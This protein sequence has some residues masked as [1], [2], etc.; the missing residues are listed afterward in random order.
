VLPAGAQELLDA[1]V[2][3]RASKDWARSDSLR[4]E[5]AA[6]GVSVEDTKDGQRWRLMGGSDGAA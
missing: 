2:A 1:R 6:L 4:G 5:L 3:A